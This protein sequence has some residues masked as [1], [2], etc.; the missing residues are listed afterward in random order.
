MTQYAEYGFQGKTAIVTGGGTG[1]GASVAV[2]L[3]KGGANVA[4]FGRRPEPVERTKKLCLEYTEG[5]L[6]MSVDVSDRNSAEKGVGIVLDRFGGADILINNAGIELK[7]EPG[8]SRF[9]DFFDA[10]DSDDYL[11][12]F[13][14]NT[15][16]HYLMNLAVIPAMRKNCFGR[17]VNVASSLGVSG[18][19]ST[20]GYTASKGAAI[21]QTKAF[22]RRYGHDN[23]TVNAVLP[24]MV[25]TPMKSDSTPE[26][27]ET[28]KRLTPLGRVAQ[29]IDLAR[30]ILFFA[31]EHL[32]VT[33][34][35]LIVSG[36][37]D[38]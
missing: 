24:G 14:V 21:T 23:I 26:E 15:L 30:V 13:R 1:I 5:V 38:I 20:P 3:A 17:I 2:E 9:W 29:P 19:Y 36:G 33:G 10:Q 34:Q 6:G 37:M 7:I 28:V 31:Q 32:F 11:E 25:D 27:Y 22:A 35:T 18:D 16:G 4:V 12:F 8:R